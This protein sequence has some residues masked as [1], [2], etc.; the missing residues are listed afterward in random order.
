[1]NKVA[2]FQMRIEFTSARKDRENEK[3]KLTYLTKKSRKKP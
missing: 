1:M 3:V 2:T